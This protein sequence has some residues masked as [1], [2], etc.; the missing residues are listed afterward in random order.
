MSEALV[1]ALDFGG[2]KNS[3]ATFRRTASGE[4]ELERVARRTSP[5]G[6][7]AVYDYATMVELARG[8]LEGR[9]PSA[10]GVSFG[11]PTRASAGV[12]VLSHHVPG[13]QEMPLAARLEEDLGARV[14]MD[15]DANVA[16]LGEARFGAGRGCASVLYITVSTGI[17]GGWVLNG[18][19]YRG[20]KEMAGEIGHM[21]IDPDGPPCVCG[22]RGCVEQM[23]SGPAM[24]RRA[25]ERLKDGARGGET[26]LRLAG[27]DP[28][29]IT[30]QL[31]AEA[32]A[33]GDTLARAALE[34]AARALGFAI[35]NVIVLMNPECVI[36]GGGVT[37]AGARYWEAV[38]AAARAN[39]MPG[40]EDAIRIV[41]A[42]RGDDAPLWGAA[43]LAEYKE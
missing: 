18:R 12:V 6:A 10:I 42:G 9:R 38:R 19:I 37:K 24:A 11:G 28:A 26:L 29:R 40:L 36:L 3:G 33:L 31:V 20:A 41:A 34:D 27:N 8:L 2:S 7:D 17:G 23:A 32:D 43:A 1:L 16:A 22:R 25:R 4:L 30:A 35:G 13:W 5:A 39:V 14:A 21:V 15:N